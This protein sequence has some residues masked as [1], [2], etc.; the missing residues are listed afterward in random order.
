MPYEQL[1]EIQSRK[2]EKI[3][4]F[5]TLENAFGLVLA[6][7]PAYLLSTNMPF[8]LRIL[9]VLTAAVLGIAA[10]LDIGSMTFYEQLIWSTRGIIRR[11]LQGSR[12]TPGQFVGTSAVAHPD[13][14]LPRGGPIRR[15]LALALAPIQVHPSNRQRTVHASEER[16]PHGRI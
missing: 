9:V 10:T 5:L 7:F 8:A 13:R 3:A 14:P 15:R 6:A 2:G 12:L 1:E 11:R 16:F 4:M